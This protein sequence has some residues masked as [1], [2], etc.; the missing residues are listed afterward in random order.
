V[1]AGAPEGA[2]RLLSKA[3]PPK[4]RLAAAFVLIAAACLAAPSLAAAAET[5]VYVQ[6]AAGI[7]YGLV[8][9]LIGTVLLG[10]WFASPWRPADRKQTEPEI[11]LSVLALADAPRPHRLPWMP[12]GDILGRDRRPFPGT[13]QPPDA[14]AGQQRVPPAP[15]GSA[16]SAPRSTS[17]AAPAATNPTPWS[18]SEPRASPDWRTTRRDD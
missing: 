9:V 16:G 13:S 3:C 17:P 6:R 2:L 14:V 12:G 11:T 15:A 7:V 4:R 18:S 10:L 8:G 5:A 1:R